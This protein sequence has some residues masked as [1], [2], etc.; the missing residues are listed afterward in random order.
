MDLGNFGRFMRYARSLALCIMII[1]VVNADCDVTWYGPYLLYNPPPTLLSHTLEDK[2]CIFCG[3]G[4]FTIKGFTMSFPKYCLYICTYYDIYLYNTEWLIRTVCYCDHN[5]ITSDT[6][7]Q[8][9]GSPTT[10]AGFTHSFETDWE[11]AAH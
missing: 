6:E 1:G 10:V 3:G 4:S 5:H 11:E 9:P 8:I 2:A 7:R